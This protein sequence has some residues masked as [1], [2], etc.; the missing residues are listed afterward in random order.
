MTVSVGTKIVLVALFSGLVA[1]FAKFVSHVLVYHKIDFVKLYQ[2]GGMPSAHSAGVVALSTMV[3][4]YEGFGSII[5]AITLYFSLIVMYDAAGIRRSAGQQA[6]VLNMIIERREI[7]DVNRLVE[8]L[9]HTPFE[10]LMGSILGI[11]MAGVF[12]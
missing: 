3:G 9:G 12:L 2:T 8:Q 6:R 5:F 10:V 1:Q 4:V 7:R 11:L